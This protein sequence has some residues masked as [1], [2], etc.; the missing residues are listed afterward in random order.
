MQTDINQVQRRSLLVSVLPFCGGKRTE[1][2]FGDASELVVCQ[3]NP[4]ELFVL[5]EHA[6][7]DQVDL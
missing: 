5:V 4:A 1:D 7:L 2:P 3:V 6:R